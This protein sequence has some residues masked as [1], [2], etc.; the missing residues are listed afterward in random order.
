M[1][2]SIERFRELVEGRHE[3]A[4]EWKAR[5]GRKVLGYFCTYVPEELV[6]AAGAL[7]IRVL[8]SHEPQGV[9]ERYIGS[10][11]CPYARDVL[12][13][14]L[15]GRYD[16]LDGV[17][18][19]TTCAHMRVA[20]SS[21]ESHVPVPY[22]YFLNMPGKVQAPEAKGYLAG[23]LALF[24]KSL[25]EWT[26]REIGDSAL[27]RAIDVYNASRR[28]LRQAYELRQK[29]RP[30]LSGA[31]AMATVLSSMLT[32]KAEHN[33]LL[34]NVLRELPAEGKRDGVRLML[35]G[36]ENDDVEMVEL[37]E[38]LGGLVVVDEHCTGSR[39]FWNEVTVPSPS[40]EA[41]GEGA[42]A[43]ARCVVPLLDAIAAR[44][45]DRPPCPIRDYEAR[46]R[47][48][49]IARLVQDFGVQG[50]IIVQQKFCDPHEFDI[51]PL[52]VFLREKLNVPSLFLE[53]DVTIPAGQFRTRIEAFLETFQNP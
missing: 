48:P 35:I 36:S 20:Y 31:E 40:A 12:A 17:A 42:S 28:L 11:Y 43:G 15:Q 21:W 2:N 8:G 50:A 13:Q 24:K 22:K 38:S 6:Y 49:H 19:A 32:D 29:P 34:E 27:D 18:I 26:G 44:Y 1:H 39:Y 33:R 53:T 52:M 7:P 41:K 16:Y 47:W 3:Y 46:R 30:P 10:M 14:G 5:T 23:E 25:G 37:A 4:R 9:T 45:L 51:P